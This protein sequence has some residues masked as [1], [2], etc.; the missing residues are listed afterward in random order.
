M[1]NA[2]PN[3]MYTAANGDVSASFA[4]GIDIRANTFN[5]SS[6][7]RRQIS[8]RQ[9]IPNGPVIAG[10]DGSYNGSTGG[11][12]RLSLFS[13]PSVGTTGMANLLLA[14]RDGGIPAIILAQLNGGPSPVSVN[15]IDDTGKSDFVQQQGYY[16]M[17]AGLGTVLGANASAMLVNAR[18]VTFIRPTYNVQMELGG[19]NTSGGSM[20]LRFVFYIDGVITL[21][22]GYSIVN[23]PG[24]QMCAYEGTVT[25]SLGSHTVSFQVLASNNAG[26]FYNYGYGKL[27]LRADA[28]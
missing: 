9:T 22:S 10:I 12:E 14:Q 25:A 27:R 13:G 20:P 7:G 26:N 17:Y 21:D 6:P 11:S 18:Q 4:G 3:Y 28:P 8:W 19:Y 2:Q 24:Y 15:V 1:P 5:P 16:E 23:L